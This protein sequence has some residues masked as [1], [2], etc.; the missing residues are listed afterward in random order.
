MKKFTFL[1][2]A[3]LVASMSFAQV[4][5]KNGR[6]AY[7]PATKTTQTSPLAKL[8]RAEIFSEDF[9]N[10]MPEGWA[11]VDSDGDGFNWESHIN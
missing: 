1:M 2:I 8:T 4:L 10:G 3:I 11:T 7:V 9:E 6:T 5:L